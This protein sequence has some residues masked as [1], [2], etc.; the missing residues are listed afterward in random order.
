MSEGRDAQLGGEVDMMKTLLGLSRVCEATGAKS[1]PGVRSESPDR[2]QA[3]E[4]GDLLGVS[5]GEVPSESCW[6]ELVRAGRCGTRVPKWLG[7]QFSG[8]WVLSRES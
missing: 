7:V 4:D 2:T 6:N 5:T 8:T 1:I 3:P